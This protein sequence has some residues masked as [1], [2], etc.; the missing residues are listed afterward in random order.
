MEQAPIRLGIFTARNL[1]TTSDCSPETILNIL[2]SLKNNSCIVDILLMDDLVPES[3]RVTE[4]KLLKLPMYIPFSQVF[5]HPK[6]NKI[7]SISDLKLAEIKNDYDM[8]I[9]AIYNDYGEDGKIL[10][11][12]E[13]LGVPYLSPS[14]KVSSV[15]FD[16][17]YTK[18]LLAHAGVTTPRSFFVDPA[19]CNSVYINSQIPTEINY[20]VVIKAVSSGNSWG[21]TIVRKSEELDKAIEAAL[22]YSQEILVE[23]Y[24]EGDEYTVGVVG[25]YWEAEVLPVVS[26][27]HTSK[28]FDYTAKYKAGGSTEICPAEVTE[29]IKK[30]L[31]NAACEAYRAVKCDSHARIDIILGK[32]GLA[33]VLD[34]NTFPG[35]NRASLFPKELVAA[36]GNLETFLKEQI[37]LKT[38]RH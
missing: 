4:D 35:L 17:Y 33:Y 19:N 18:A 32:D 24:V 6:I 9:V 14:Q 23:A 11:M 5:E 27:T 29:D 13:L 8:A 36:G 34:I 25:N 2:D 10:G 30:L 28:F 26:I 15:C 31:Q 37:M 1:K 12:L 7:R 38:A 22:E 16:K 3:K 21:V 20:P